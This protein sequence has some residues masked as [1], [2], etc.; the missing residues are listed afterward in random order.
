MFALGPA[1]TTIV[2]FIVVFG[3]L[4]AIFVADDRANRRR[5]D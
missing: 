3:I 2:F 4:G 1:A 5:H